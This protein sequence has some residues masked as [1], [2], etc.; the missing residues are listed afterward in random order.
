LTAIA[1]SCGCK[2]TPTD[3]DAIRAGIFQHLT[4]LKTLNTS[5]MDLDINNISIQGTQAHVQVTF[6]PKTGAPPGAGMQVAYQLEKRDSGWFVVK[7][8]GVGG[9]IAHPAANANPQLQSG[10]S[11]VHGTMPNFRELIP[12]T[13]P[14]SSATLP[15]GHPP[16]DATAQTKP[17]NPDGKPD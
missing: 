1:L 15:T 9:G 8:E 14:A 5:A 2:N 11:D 16:I 12:A 13:T 4:S 17:A 7:T 6:R 3:A 10:Q